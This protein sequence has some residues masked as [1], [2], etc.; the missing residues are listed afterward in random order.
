MA[1]RSSR[2]IKLSEIIRGDVAINR[3]NSKTRKTDPKGFSQSG[4]RDYIYNFHYTKLPSSEYYLVTWMTNDSRGGEKCSIKV[5]RDED[6]EF[7]QDT[8]DPSKEH[9]L[10]TRG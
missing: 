5:T 8:N 2:N 6:M 9:K 4:G 1:G 10:F 7:V 3:V